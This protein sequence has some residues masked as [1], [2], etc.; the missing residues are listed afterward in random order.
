MPATV[1][2]Q[3]HAW[4]V[5]IVDPN[6]VV[7]ASTVIPIEKATQAAVTVTK[8]E[9]SSDNASYELAGDVKFADAR[10]G[11]ANA[12]V[13]DPFDT[14]SGVL[15]DSSIGGDATIPSGKFVYLQFDSAPNAS[16]GDCIITVYWDYD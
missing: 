14:S 11:L 1:S 12:T 10:I 7:T 6:T 5:S 13:V 15:S 8:I 9:A 16:M 2:G 4:S 3:R